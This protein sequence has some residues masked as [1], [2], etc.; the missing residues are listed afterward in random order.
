MQ[1]L[2]INTTIMSEKIT[3]SHGSGGRQAQ[4]LIRDHFAARFDM[5][6]PMTDSALLSVPPGMIAFTTDSYVIDPLFFPGGNIGKLAVCG[7]VNDLAVSGAEPKYLSAAFIIEEGF[8][9]DELDEIVASMAD[10]AVAAG[11]RI[12]TGDTK[13]VEK[14]PV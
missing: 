11:V 1:Y 14:G 5:K 10:E 8:G 4:A 9:F 6:G 7:T 12:V 13:V 2:I 3:L